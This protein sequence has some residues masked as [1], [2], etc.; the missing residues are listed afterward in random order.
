MTV[1]RDGTAL[2]S[3]LAPETIASCFCRRWRRASRSSRPTPRASGRPRR[4]SPA[5]PGRG[6]TV[7]APAVYG[8]GDRETL[9]YFK[10]RRPRSRP[11]AQ[12]AGCP[13]LADPCRGP[14]RGAGACRSTGRLALGSTKSMT[15]GK[16]A[17]ATATWRA[18]AASGAGPHGPRRWRSR[19]VLMDGSRPDQRHRPALGGPVQILTPGKVRGI[20]HRDWTVHDRRLAAALGFAARYDLAAGFRRH[21]LVVPPARMALG[22]VKHGV[23]N[24]YFTRNCVFLPHT[25]RPEPP[26][27]ERCSCALPTI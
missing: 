14:G 7:R 17:T 20:F 21:D 12:P 10:C 8:P 4:W 22:R 23:T 9:A 19:P 25:P 26:G 18:A 15:A 16:A 5:A 1:N 27:P 2:L 3:A 11:P 13:A 24:C 6:S